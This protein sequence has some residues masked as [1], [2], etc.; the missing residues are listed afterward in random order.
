[1][2]RLLSDAS[3]HLRSGSRGVAKVSRLLVAM[4]LASGLLAVPVTQ[5]NAVGGVSMNVPGRFCRT[6]DI[7]KRIRTAKYGTLLCKREGNRA[8]WKRA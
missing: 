7:G 4:L 2:T 8:R 3:F 5:A 1:M 6:A